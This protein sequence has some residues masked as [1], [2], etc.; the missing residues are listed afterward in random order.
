MKILHIIDSLDPRGGGPQAVA[1]RLAAAQTNPE[2]SVAI[3]TH[4]EN[5]EVS[6]R[7][8]ISKTGIPAIGAVSVFEVSRSSNLIGRICAT[9]IGDWI[10]KHGKNWDVLH[11]HNVWDPSVRA[12]TAAAKKKKI[13]YVIVPH[14]SL[15]PWAM[16]QSFRKSFKKKLAL[17]FQLRALINAATFI[18]ALNSDEVRGISSLKFTAPIEIIPNGIFPSE[19]NSL[20][21]DGVF[22]KKFPQLGESPFIIFLSRL[23]FKKGLDILANAFIYAKNKNKEL[24]LVIAG[25]DEGALKGFMEQITAAKLT[26]CVHIVGP[27]YGEIKF[28]ALVDATM[29]CL[30]S[31]M[32]GFSIAILEAL[33]CR[34]PVVISDNC[35]F[36]EVKANNAGITTRLD[37][38]EIGDAFL[39]LI[40]DPQFREKCI[41]NGH[42]MV[43]QSY[44]WLVISKQIK[45][46][47]NNYK[48]CK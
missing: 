48:I 14:A 40:S 28:A 7:I 15:D 20:P 2:D 6:N 11:I 39:K 17:L 16:K 27:L 4:K 31:R 22:R 38:E 29:F 19:Y 3:L 8:E 34:C 41:Q 47:Y 43:H 21:A 10:Y 35:N 36:P 18:H 45:L 25:P 42:R 13:P 26:S 37:S 44:S 32:E 1:L 24:Q 5:V 46:I 23:H 30:P 12:A 9:S 33:A